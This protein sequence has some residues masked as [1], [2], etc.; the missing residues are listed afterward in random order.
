MKISIYAFWFPPDSDVGGR[1]WG[2]FAQELADRG[3]EIIVTTPQVQEKRAYWEKSGLNFRGITPPRF[4]QSYGSSLSRKLCWHA[5]KAFFRLRYSGWFWDPSITLKAQINEFVNHDISNEVDVIVVSC[6]P[7]R[8]AFHISEILSQQSKRPRF[9][10]DLRDP[11][12]KNQLAY[13][14]SL[15]KKRIEQELELEASA[16]HE[17]DGVILTHEAMLEHYGPKRKVFIPNNIVVPSGT[18][19]RKE[20]KSELKLI[21]PGSLYAQGHLELAD[22]LKKC[23]R[24]V[25]DLNVSLTTLGNWKEDV[26]AL[27]KEICE[28][29]HLGMVEQKLVEP[30][31]KQH[32][33]VLTY[34]SP[35]LS[36]AINTK[37]IEAIQSKTPLIL[38]GTCSFSEFI[39]RNKVGWIYDR[40]CSEAELHEEIYRNAEFGPFIQEEFSRTEAVERLM[41]FISE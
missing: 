39:T 17:A 1:R 9:Y 8:W 32:H 2:I 26:I 27:L 12:T 31:L 16:I 13:F 21:F 19:L 15:S 18:W 33:Y 29:N 38:L 30:L 28:V 41:R 35:L 20:I 37:I 5:T 4:P 6:A 10:V 40:A 25:P 34:V 36:Y 14:N 23:I 11:W 22:F 7:F 24:A 3:H